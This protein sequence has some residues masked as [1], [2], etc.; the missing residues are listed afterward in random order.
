MSS[1]EYLESEPAIQLS[2][3]HKQYGWGRRA[4][5]VLKGINMDVPYHGMLVV[6][7]LY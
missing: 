6:R 2:N 3:V 5:K 4:V 1:H 7:S